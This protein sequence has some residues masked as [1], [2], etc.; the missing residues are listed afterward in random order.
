M[1][2]VNVEHMYTVNTV[3]RYKWVACCMTV[4]KAHAATSRK[5][6]HVNEKLCWT[7]QHGF[8]LLLIGTCVYVLILSATGWEFVLAPG[9]QLGLL[10]RIIA[11]METVVGAQY[12]GCN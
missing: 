4:C 7:V 12:S 5:I 6:S 1:A 8:A 11:A 3:Q 9:S 2:S 10:Q